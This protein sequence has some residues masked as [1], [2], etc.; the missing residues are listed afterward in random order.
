[1]RAI[2]FSATTVHVASWARRASLIASRCHCFEMSL[3]TTPLSFL[4]PD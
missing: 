4:V 2:D 3:P 1:M